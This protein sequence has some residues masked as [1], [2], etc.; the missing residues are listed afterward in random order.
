MPNL[1]FAELI[2]FETYIHLHRIISFEVLL[3]RQVLHCP[4]YRL[5]C[6]IVGYS[7]TGFFGF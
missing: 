2:L 3:Q 6:L 7:F 1:N 4:K 5:E